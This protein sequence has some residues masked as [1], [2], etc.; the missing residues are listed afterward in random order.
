[1]PSILMLHEHADGGMPQSVED[2]VSLLR[3]HGMPVETMA[4]DMTDSRPSLWRGSQAGATYNRLS[5]AIQDCGAQVLHIHNRWPSVPSVVYRA[6]RDANLA[7]VQSLEERCVSCIDKG[8]RNCQG[9]RSG[10][11]GVSPAKG[12]RAGMRRLAALWRQ[13]VD[14]FVARDDVTRQHYAAAGLPLR[15]IALKPDV[16]PDPGRAASTW[17]RPRQGV[18]VLGAAVDM[19]ELGALLNDLP[20]PVTL[21]GEGMNS[22]D[23]GSGVRQLGA[24]NRDA[25][26]REMSMAQLLLLPSLGGEAS[27]SSVFDALAHGLPVLGAQPGVLCP[28]VTGELLPMDGRDGWREALLA[29]LADRKRLIRMGEASRR[30]YEERYA[31]AVLYRTAMD[32]YRAAIAEAP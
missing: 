32:I 13:Q 25:L 1:M 28:G 14:R 20:V 3:R 24:L 4:L 16:C 23:L 30:L 8:C 27:C 11:E 2:E 7:V 17:G 6:A 21:I 19:P 26:S 22:L 29:M 18:L 10:E 15:R 5:Q 9:R 31:P 12:L